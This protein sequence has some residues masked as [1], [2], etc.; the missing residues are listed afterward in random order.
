[1][2]IKDLITEYLKGKGWVYGGTIE[3]Y[4]RSVAGKKA[5]NASRRL[6]E[7]FNDGKIER[8][9]VKCEVAGNKVV[10]Y[11]IKQEVKEEPIKIPFQSGFNLGVNFD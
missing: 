5:S 1:M 8:Q 9:L 10:Q 3:D 7:L 6:R 2:S 11:R 4:V